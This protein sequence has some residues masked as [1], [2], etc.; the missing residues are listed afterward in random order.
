MSATKELLQEGRYRISQPTTDS[1]NETVYDAYDTVRNTNVLVKEIP[2]T[3]G[4]AGS[5]A[6]KETNA[7]A[8]AAEAKKLTRLKHDSLLHV[9]DFFSDTDRQYLVMEAVDGDSLQELMKRNDRPFPLADVLDWADRLL[10]A[11]NYLHTSAT[12][13]F[14]KNVRPENIVLGSNGRIKLLGFTT[15]NDPDADSA[16]CYSPLEQVWGGLDSASQNAII[17]SLDERAERILK[18]PA[19]ARS[20]IYSLGATFYFL[21]TGREPVSA[22]ERAIEVFDGSPDPLKEPTKLNARIPDEISDVLMKAMEIRRENRYDSAVIMRQVLKTALVR[23]KERLKSELGSDAAAAEFLGIKEKPRM[24]V[25]DQLLELDAPEVSF[26]PDSPAAG[27]SP[28]AADIKAKAESTSARATSTASDLPSFVASDEPAHSGVSMPMIG[29]GAAAFLGIIFAVW[30]FA[31]SGSSEK[32]PETPA[33]TATQ[34][35][36]PPAQSEVPAQSATEPEP[37]PVTVSASDP[38]TPAASESSPAEHKAASKTAPAPTP[39]DK[40][41]AETPAKAPAKEKKPVTVDDLING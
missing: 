34:P 19:D 26:P 40:K 8:F 29:I 37:A 39:K 1:Q 30:F 41:Q 10:D 6:Q 14:H 31:F 35:A 4:K 11:L 17:N 36:T 20:D 9:E 2:L 38:S 12:P 16:L 3:F 7:Q 32:T 28:G 18:E 15:A 5:L 22:L 13:V 24:E 27:K 23:A 21:V 25:E 33:A